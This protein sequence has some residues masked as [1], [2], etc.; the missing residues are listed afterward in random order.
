MLRVEAC[1]D[2]NL[3][4]V[5]FPDPAFPL[6]RKDTDFTLKPASD[7]M[8]LA[9]DSAECVSARERYGVFPKT[10][11]RISQAFG[12]CTTLLLL[13]VSNLDRYAAD[14]ANAF[15]QSR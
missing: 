1:S 5:D 13:T 6:V 14:R 8:L 9:E 12:Y 3:V 10:Q 11:V 7:S 2:R 4:K 15:A